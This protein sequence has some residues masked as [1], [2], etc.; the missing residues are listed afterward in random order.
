MVASKI[1]ADF[2]KLVIFKSFVVYFSTFFSNNDKLFLL[3]FSNSFL[4]LIKDFGL[5]S[6]KHVIFKSFVANFGTF[7]LILL[8]CFC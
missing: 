2:G 5:I 4:V 7:F 1:S 3:I 6:V 8:D